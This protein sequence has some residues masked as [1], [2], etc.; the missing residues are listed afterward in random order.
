M[1]AKARGRS[2]SENKIKIKKRGAK[3][4]RSRGGWDGDVCLAR[5]SSVEL[6]LPAHRRWALL[7][8]PKSGRRESSPGLIDTQASGH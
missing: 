3:C 7:D 2:C 8:V 4:A 6:L 1:G 5:S